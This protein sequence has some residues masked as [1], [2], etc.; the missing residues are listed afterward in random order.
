M[1][2]T[3]SC[4]NPSWVGNTETGG[5]VVTYQLEIYL[6]LFHSSLETFPLAARRSHQN[7]STLGHMVNSSLY[8]AL[9]TSLLVLEASAVCCV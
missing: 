3:A 2:Y 6:H 5:K 8:V 4:R 7:L 9:S 1:Y